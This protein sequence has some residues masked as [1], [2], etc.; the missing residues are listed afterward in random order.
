[1]VFQDWLRCVNNSPAD[2]ALPCFQDAIQT[3]G[4]PS[5]IRCDLVVE[6]VDIAR[7]MLVPCDTGRKLWNQY[8][9]VLS[10]LQN[11]RT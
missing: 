5:C 6:N 1:M 7:F 4:I 9:Q 3:Y 11:Y 10:T 2:T 8:L